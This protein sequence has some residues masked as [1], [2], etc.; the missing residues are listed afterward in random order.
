MDAL[1]IRRY[2]PSDRD[3]VWA[4]HED[5]LSA[6]GAHA[7]HGPWDDDLHDIEAVYLGTGGDFLVGV[8]AGRI[9]AMGALKRTAPSRAEIKRM[10]VRPAL[11]GQ[12]FGQALLS[13][14]EHRARDLGYRTL[15]LDT[16]TR[17]EA[18]RHLYV[19]NGYHEVRRSA[20]Q[21]LHMIF[22]E[23]A[24]TSDGGG[25]DTTHVRLTY[26][27]PLP[28]DATT[29]HARVGLTDGAGRIVPTTTLDPDCADDMGG[30]G[31]QS[32]EATVVFPPQPAGARLTLTITALPVN[33]RLRP[34]PWRFSFAVP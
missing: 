21:G 28:P 18:A 6:V 8:V 4:L 22:Y 14:L 26:T 31:G 7:G 15:H 34:G 30:T 13:A 1:R 2:Q 5:A 19:K 25:D 11:Q 12:G 29:D 23:K 27:H 32:C 33:N 9:A 17:Q 3:A 10:R 24:L 20:W 16:T